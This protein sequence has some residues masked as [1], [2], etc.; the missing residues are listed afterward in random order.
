MSGSGPQDRDESLLG[1]KPFLVLADHLSRNGVAVLRYDD[2]G[3]AKS[4]GTFAGC[5]SADFARDAHAAVAF[6][7][8]RPGIDPKRVGICGHSEGGLIGPM[9]AAAHPADIA[10]LVL[11]AGPGLPGDE[12]LKTQVRDIY[13]AEG[14]DEK[15][16]AGLVA[17][18]Q[19]SVGAMKKPWADPRPVLAAAAG[20]LTGAAKDKWKPKAPGDPW[21]RFFVSHDPR[22]DLRKLTCPVL[23]LNGEKDLQVAAGENLAA[24]KAACPHADCRPLPGLNHL[25]Q[26]CKT[27]GIAEY[28][29]IETTLD[30]AVLRAVAE[31]VGKR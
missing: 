19:L 16:V 13:K 3:V 30:P 25:F 14:K 4:G 9:V 29:E 27:G 2:R 31:W 17:L 10:F 22:P 26:P 6:L 23:A 8:G 11:L 12:I 18:N 21:M 5:T 1:H 7:R 15:A 20:G 28:S 24:I